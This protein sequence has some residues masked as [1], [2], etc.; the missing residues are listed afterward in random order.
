LGVAH[1]IWDRHEKTPLRDRQGY[2]KRHKRH[3][4]CV[5]IEPGDR[6]RS[7]PKD[8]LGDAQEPKAEVSEKVKSRYEQRSVASGEK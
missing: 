7:V 8:E 1:N 5:H 2:R 3:P 6:K 4:V